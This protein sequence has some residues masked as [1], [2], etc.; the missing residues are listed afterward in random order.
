MGVAAALAFGG[1]YII[2]KVIDLLIGVRV[3]HEIEDIGLDIGEHAESA[4]SDEEEFRL[5]FHEHKEKEE[6]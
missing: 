3:S 5:D 1:T 4:Y 2:M 6:H